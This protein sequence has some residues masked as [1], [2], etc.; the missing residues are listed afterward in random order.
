MKLFTFELRNV[1]GQW[2]MIT[3]S[4][5]ESNGKVYTNIANINPVPLT[6]KKNGLPEGKNELK[7]FDIDEADMELFESF[8]EG[9]KEKIRKSPEWQRLYGDPSTSSNIAPSANFDDM[10]DDLPF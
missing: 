2:A 10:A 6:I 3:V 4:E 8:S 5:N 1:L 9:L 7:I